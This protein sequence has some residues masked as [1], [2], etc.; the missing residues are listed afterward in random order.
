M[1]KLY[2]QIM[3]KPLMQRVCKVKILAKLLSWEAIVYIFFG[4]LATLV[5]W[6]S[7]LFFKTVL[8]QTTGVS[9]AAAWVLAMVFAFYTNKTFVF[10]SRQA[11][12]KG[13]ARE[14]AL[15]AAARLLSFGFDEAFMIIAVDKIGVPDGLAKILSN[16]FVLIMNYFASKIIIFKNKPD[17]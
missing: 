2:Q 7:Y 12:W 9:N 3:A 11:S 6:A 1:E 15:F 16:I 8:N 10:K 4:A 13:V 17:C 5:N 14:F